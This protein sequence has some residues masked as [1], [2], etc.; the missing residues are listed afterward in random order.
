M[1]SVLQTVHEK[2]CRGARADFE[3]TL[4]LCPFTFGPSFKGAELNIHHKQNSWGYKHHKHSHSRT[5]AILPLLG[6]ACCPKTI[7]TAPT[8][9][10]ALVPPIPGNARR[11]NPL[12]E[13]VQSRAPHPPAQTGAKPCQ[14]PKG[15]QASACL[16]GT[17]KRGYLLCNHQTW[18]CNL[19]LLHN[20]EGKEERL[21][22][23]RPFKEVGLSPL[24]YALR[25]SEQQG[26]VL[27]MQRW[28]ICCWLSPRVTPCCLPS[29]A[30]AAS[31]ASLSNGCT[32][33]ISWIVPQ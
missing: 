29:P 21:W 22:L 25:R 26:R 3:N 31:P 1:L 17:Q 10:P 27:C 6:P 7:L 16:P 14:L 18:K 15:M 23:Q 20:G 30:A 24:F 19:C 28:I 5:A 12:L 2:E 9:S 8:A 11:K 4:F 32:S 13:T 33:V